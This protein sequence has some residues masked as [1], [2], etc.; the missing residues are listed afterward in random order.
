MRTTLRNA[1]GPA[2]RRRPLQRRLRPQ[3]PTE[4]PA[5]VTFQHFARFTSIDPDE[6]RRRFYVLRWQSSLFGGGLLVQTWGRI[7]TQGASRSAA[8]LDRDSAT[9]TVARLVRRRL[10]RRYEVGDWR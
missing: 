4:T 8:F 3:L 2:R 5:V 10:Q 1:P 7:G 6:N 9:A